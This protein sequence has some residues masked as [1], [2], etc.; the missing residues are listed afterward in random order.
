VHLN[1]ADS[2]QLVAC[3]FDPR[4]AQLPIH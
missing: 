4:C 1:T 2:D 3:N